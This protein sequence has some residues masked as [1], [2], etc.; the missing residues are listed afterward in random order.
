MVL[1]APEARERCSD[2]AAKSALEDSLKRELEAVNAQLD[3]H[4]R[5]AFIAIAEGPWTVATGVV[6]STLKIKRAVIEARYQ[7]S[8]RRVAARED[9]SVSGESAAAVRT[10]G[11]PLTG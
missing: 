9:A 1:L 8:F 11:A 2:P 4:E 7:K 5:I 10:Q 6:H 3:A